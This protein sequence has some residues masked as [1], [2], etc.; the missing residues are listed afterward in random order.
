MQSEKL[1][2]EHVWYIDTEDKG[3][4]PANVSNKIF[5]RANEVGTADVYLGQSAAF[6]SPS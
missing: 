4:G 1:D 5:L 3:L 6:P 2:R